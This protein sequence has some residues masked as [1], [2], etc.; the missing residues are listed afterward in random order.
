MKYLIEKE[1]SV[2]GPFEIKALHQMRT[3][4]ALSDETPCC[5]EG[6]D[7]WLPSSIILRAQN[8]ARLEV[9]LGEDRLTRFTSFL[10]VPL[11]RTELKLSACEG[12]ELENR[13]LVRKGTSGTPLAVGGLWQRSDSDS[14]SLQLR[15][16]LYGNFQGWRVLLASDRGPFANRFADE[17]RA[18]CGFKYIPLEESDYTETRRAA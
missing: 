1:A 18:L 6:E 11:G 14:E 16:R 13:N 5:R 2:H 12:L 9:R 15:F 3:L 8:Q 4:G 10:S 7:L 17:V